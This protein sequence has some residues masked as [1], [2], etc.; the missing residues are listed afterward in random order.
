M[1][2]RLA[3]APY[4]APSAVRGARKTQCGCNEWSTTSGTPSGWAAGASAATLGRDPVPRCEAMLWRG[5]SG[6]G[7]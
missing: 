7:M 4:W 2:V 6:S 1:M 3:S 5:S